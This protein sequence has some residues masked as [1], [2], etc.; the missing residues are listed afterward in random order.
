ML[1]RE[2][3]GIDLILGGHT[4]TFLEAPTVLKN[5]LGKAV[6][7]NQVGWGGVRLGRIDLTLS[8]KKDPIVA[9]AHTV[10]VRKQTIG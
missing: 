1:A 8:N 3:H 10:V 6:A 4:H 7:V 9:N 2:T 5:A